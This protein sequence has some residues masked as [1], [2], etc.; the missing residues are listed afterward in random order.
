MLFFFLMF[1]FTFLRGGGGH[2]LHMEDRTQMKVIKGGLGWWCIDK[3]MGEACKFLYNVF[4]L[5]FNTDY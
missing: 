5:F 4:F 1:F 2:G 3:W